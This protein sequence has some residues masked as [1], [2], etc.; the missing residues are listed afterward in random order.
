ML[1]KRTVIG[2]FILLAIVGGTLWYLRVQRIM[3]AEPTRVYRV[4]QMEKTTRE[5]T[6]HREA[7]L[8]QQM[9]AADERFERERQQR[10]ERELPPE[11]VTKQPV[12]VQDPLLQGLNDEGEPYWD[13]LG[14][15]APAPDTPRPFKHLT[16]VELHMDRSKLTP[17]ERRL[18]HNEFYFRYPE[19]GKRRLEAMKR[20]AEALERS[21]QMDEE[22]KKLHESITKRAREQ[23]RKERERQPRVYVQDG[24]SPELRRIR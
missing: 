12:A 22:R 18:L 9:K 7:D 19:K 24:S 1:K 8:Q 11:P 6:V 15:K 21:R 13:E 14:G 10:A 16:Y 5:T 3:N 17:K 2:A 23:R 20:Y 4:P